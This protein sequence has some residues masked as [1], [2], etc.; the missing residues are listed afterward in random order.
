MVFKPKSLYEKVLKFLGS[1]KFNYLSYKSHLDNVLESDVVIDLVA[2]SSWADLLD[3]LRRHG[4]YAVAGAVAGPIVSL[5]VRTLYL[6]DLS[7]FGCTALVSGVFANL[8]TLIETGSIKP[9]V[10]EVFPLKQIKQAQQT[11]AEKN[12]IGKIVLDIASQ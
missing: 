1:K 11:F 9:L 6:K 3:V 2:G 7:F 4:R 10:A 5:D 8:V 12:Y